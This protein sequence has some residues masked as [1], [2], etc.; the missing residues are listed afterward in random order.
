VTCNTR[1]LRSL[2]DFFH[3]L[4][5][6]LDCSDSCSSSSA[7][8]NCSCFGGFWSCLYTDA[9]FVPWC[10]LKDWSDLQGSTCADATAAILLQFPGM[11]V[12]CQNNAALMPLEDN[13]ERYIVVVDATEDIVSS[14]VFNRNAE[15][16]TSDD[17]FGGGNSCDVYGQQCTFETTEYSAEEKTCMST[18]SS[19][20]CEFGSFVCIDAVEAVACS[21][22]SSGSNP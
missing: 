4:D 13:L 10:F 17:F 8:S 22:S 5:S 7:E 9:C 2:V 19:C 12:Y 16:P 11:E 6:T 3:F 1:T 20:T 21:V 14:V 18:T 15:C